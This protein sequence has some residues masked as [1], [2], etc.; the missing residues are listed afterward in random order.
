[1]GDVLSCGFTDLSPAEAGAS[2]V[3]VITISRL[4]C[5]MS[6][7]NY[8]S[9]NGCDSQCFYLQELQFKRD[10]FQKLLFKYQE[11]EAGNPKE[12]C[13]SNNTN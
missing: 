9:G 8:F 4:D 7:T 2:S 6:I 3:W 1:M 12:Q 13:F 10:K 5:K 11:P